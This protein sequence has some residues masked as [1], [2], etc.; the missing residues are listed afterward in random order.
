MNPLLWSAWWNLRRYKSPVL[1]CSGHVY[2]VSS[3]EVCCKSCFSRDCS[4]ASLWYHRYIVTS[5]NAFTGY[6]FWSA[7]HLSKTSW[8]TIS[9]CDF[10]K[11]TFEISK[12]LGGYWAVEGLLGVSDIH[13]LPDRFGSNHLNG[14]TS[15]ILQKRL[16][17][18]C[19]SSLTVSITLCYRAHQ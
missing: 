4:T 12:T 17:K 1:C 7:S 2:P 10:A 6:I 14:F 13:K 18:S 5:I 19:V 16:R 9:R 8:S 15:C 3:P 11:F